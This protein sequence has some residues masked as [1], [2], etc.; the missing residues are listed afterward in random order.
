MMCY[1]QNCHLSIE[2]NNRGLF[3]WKCEKSRR[4]AE[5]V[6]ESPIKK[7]IEKYPEEKEVLENLSIDAWSKVIF[8]YTNTPE[9]NYSQWLTNLKEIIIFQ[10]RR[11]VT[12]FAELSAKAAKERP[13]TNLFMEILDL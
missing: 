5:S 13:S 12:L 9:Q 4:A 7:L 8:Y 6:K 10:E 2:Y 1:N 3:C 11:W